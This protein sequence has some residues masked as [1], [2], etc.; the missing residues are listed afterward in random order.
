MDI[1][2]VD[3]AK[4]VFQLH[5]A[6]RRGNALHCSN[7]MRAEL[8]GAVQKLQPR[9]IDMEACSSAHHWGRQFI[10]LRIE[11]CPISPAYV[12]LFV[13]INTMPPRS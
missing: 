4:Q 6:D 1:L 11:V 5:G 10:E 9:I 3:L 12:A 2:G 7:V 8:L 13:K